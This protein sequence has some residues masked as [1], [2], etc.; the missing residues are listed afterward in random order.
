MLFSGISTPGSE[1]TTSKSE[2]AQTCKARHVVWYWHFTG[3]ALQVLQGLSWFAPLASMLIPSDA[4]SALRSFSAFTPSTYLAQQKDSW[5]RETKLD[6]SKFFEHPSSHVKSL[7]FQAGASRSFGS[8]V[9]GTPGATGVF[10]AWRR[11]E[12]QKYHS[13]FEKTLGC[14]TLLSHYII[15]IHYILYASKVTQSFLWPTVPFL[16][17]AGAH[18]AAP[19]SKHD[20][21][22]QTFLE[23]SLWA[24]TIIVQKRKQKTS[25]GS[26]Q[27]C[28]FDLG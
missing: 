17:Q 4:N 8:Q 12:E 2:G 19:R 9:G 1:G 18:T 16:A 10:F 13:F 27:K 26:L 23:W 6:P 7:G 20:I 5:N 21:S 3:Y 11:C 14:H 28:I 22:L 25:K 15:T 24:R